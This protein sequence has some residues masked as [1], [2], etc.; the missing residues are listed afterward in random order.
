MEKVVLSSLALIAAWVLLSFSSG[1]LLG[2][3]PLQDLAASDDAVPESPLEAGD[4]LGT[5]RLEP[6]LKIELVAAEPI[7]V[8]PCSI[9]FDAEGRMFVAENRGY[10]SGVKPGEPP[11]GV[12][13]MLEDSNGDGTFEKRTAFATG[14]TFPNGV[15]PWKGGLFVTCAPDLFYLK[16]KDGDGHADE[17]RVVFTGFDTGGSTQLRVCHPTLSPDNWIYLSGGLRGGSITS[18]DHPD[19]PAVDMSRGDFRFL[20]DTG[21]F[22]MTDGKGQ[23]GLTFD[24]FGRRFFCFNR[25]HAQHVVL[26]SRYLRR[27]AHLAFSETVQNLPENMQ[28]D[29]LGGNNVAARIFPISRNFTTADSHAGQFSAACGVLL[30]R[31]S[32]LPESY[33]G[34]FFTCDPTGNLVHRDRLV[35]AGATYIARRAAEGVEMLAS[36]DNWFRPVN[37]T[38]GP[39]GALYLCDMYRKTIEHP[40]YL[41]EEV[42]KRTD[43]ES[44]KD[45]GRIWRVT[46]SDV[47]RDAS[48]SRPDLSRADVAELC[49]LLGHPIAWQR[50][51][52]HRLLLERGDPGAVPLLRAALRRPPAL[53]AAGRSRALRLLDG[54]GGLDEE[55]IALAMADESPGVREEGLELAE[56][57]LMS[58][59]ALRRQALRLA[60]DPD[61]RV[62]FQAALTLG[63]VDEPEA[64]D[65]LARIAMRDADDRWARAAVLSSAGGRDDALLRAILASPA[66]VSSGPGLLLGEL[67]RMLA[68]SQPAGRQLQV[69][70]EIVGAEEKADL[71]RHLAAAAG[72]AE[73]LR[74]AG[75]GAAGLSPLQ[76][77][78]DG[79]GPAAAQAKRRVARLAERSAVLAIDSAQPLSLRLAAIALIGHGLEQGAAA[80]LEAL[81]DGSQPAGVQQAAVRALFRLPGDAAAKGRLSDE[82]WKS[83]SPLL[84]E[85]VL[86]ASMAESRHVRSLLSALEAGDVPI[87]AVDSARR[88]QLSGHR[89]EKIRER[90]AALFKSLQSGDRMKVYE[91]L[92]QVLALPAQPSNGRAVFRKTCAQCHRLDQ[93]GAAVGPDLFDTRNQPKE[94][95]LLHILVPEYEVTHGFESYTLETRDG[96]LLSGI[97]A[98]ET[99]A[100]VTLR[101]AL[102]AEETILRGNIVSLTSSALSLMPQE[103]EKTLSRQELADLVAYL[104]GEE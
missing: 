10:P 68:A 43:F 1:A 45:L 19:R 53:P 69:L 65:A 49:R 55:S 12:I 60:D 20:P 64:L 81:L 16:D 30:N 6:G 26:A 74:D 95:I 103:L 37:L 42:R 44:G 77:L 27:N 31:G 38:I 41:P 101:Q 15:L 48:E 89:D 98:S 80:R 79:G 3:A 5:F 85:A 92:K 57:R 99:P 62:R 71:D 78:L 51:T 2:A 18:P 24:D 23:F 56:S 29:L 32:A 75:P 39:D 94:S 63:E 8:A 83:Y 25:I 104:K 67:G 59:P 14:L 93:E 34:N 4:E 97:I 50:D 91:D 35:P 96:R 13:A 28:K 9:A 72:F 47:K 70:Q 17:R 61:P 36:A 21:T 66:G 84:R 100:S 76:A 88:R 87:G 52:A 22:E 90:A 7:V 82:S 102:G 86:A 54:L 58:A 46:A 11:A 73:G 40:E 33:D